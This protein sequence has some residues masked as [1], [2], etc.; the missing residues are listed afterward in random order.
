MI[1][2]YICFSIWTI[3]GTCI[4]IYQTSE[5]HDLWH[6]YEYNTFIW[7]NVSF[8]QRKLQPLRLSRIKKIWIFTS[9]LVQLNILNTISLRHGEIHFRKNGIKTCFYWWIFVFYSCSFLVFY[10]LFPRLCKAC[11]MIW[12]KSPNHI[13]FTY[14]SYRLLFLKT[15]WINYVFNSWW[16]R[17][18]GQ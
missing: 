11:F 13:Y 3:L 9:C 6:I 2:Y 5:K 1:P 10:I 8:W 17:W 7:K 14:T 15:R 4:V 12:L 18:W 16:Y